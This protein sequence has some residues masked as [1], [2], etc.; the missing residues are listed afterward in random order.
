MM[1][2]GCDY[3]PSWQQVSWF[4]SETGETGDRK[5]VRAEG[6]ARVFYEQV[7]GAGADPV[8]MAVLFT[9]EFLC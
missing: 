7:V 8:K 2:L 4:D 1:I 5:L 6:E 9:V 3:H